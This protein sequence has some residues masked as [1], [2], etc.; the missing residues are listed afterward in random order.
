[1]AAT[2]QPKFHQGFEPLPQ[3]FV[4]AE[5]GD[6]RVD[7]NVD[8]PATCAI[9]C[10]PLQGE[11]GVRPLEPEYLRAIRNCATTTGCC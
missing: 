1:V 6:P 5:F 4:H 11:S 8:H 10:E 9:L 7:R 3:G 2:G